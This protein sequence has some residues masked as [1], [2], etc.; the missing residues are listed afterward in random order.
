M[1]NGGRG[2][3]FGAVWEKIEYSTGSFSWASV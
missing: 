1:G 3:E 2:N